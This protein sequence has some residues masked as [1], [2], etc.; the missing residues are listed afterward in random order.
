MSWFEFIFGRSNKKV[1]NFIEGVLK[2]GTRPEISSINV[3]NLYSEFV[4]EFDDFR[5]T[6]KF[7]LSKNTWE[8]FSVIDTRENGCTLFLFN[9]SRYAINLLRKNYNLDQLALTQKE[10]VEYIINKYTN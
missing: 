3:G 10:N 1:N 7:C 6:I 2:S 9:E 5:I 8:H 4:L